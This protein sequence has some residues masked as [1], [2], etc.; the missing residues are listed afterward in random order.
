MYI[1][2]GHTVRHMPESASSITSGMHEQSCLHSPL[3]QCGKYILTIIIIVSS[4]TA[5]MGHG[6]SSVCCHEVWPLPT[7]HL[8]NWKISG[9][10]IANTTYTMKAFHTNICHLYIYACNCLFCKR[11]YYCNYYLQHLTYCITYV[12]G[13]PNHI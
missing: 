4:V 6:H 11:Y 5:A 12:Y 1:A 9:V 10:N 3:L 2:F 8:H 7:L 13:I